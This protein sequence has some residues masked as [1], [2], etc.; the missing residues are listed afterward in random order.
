MANPEHV[1]IVRR[2]AEAIREWQDSNSGVQLDLRKADLSGV[3][4]IGAA[5][6]NADLGEATLCG[7]NLSG[8]ILY[9]ATLCEANLKLANLYE[10]KLGETNLQKA[11]LSDANLR[12]ASLKAANLAAANLTRANLAWADLRGANLPEANL[13]HA[14]LRGANLRGAVL[15]RAMLHFAELDGSILCDV[16][17]SG[18][19]LCNVDLRA[20]NLCSANL[21]GANLS[22]AVV[23]WT[24]FTDLDLSLV[25]QLET[26]RHGA[27][28]SVGIDTLYKSR[29][30]IPISFLS[31]CGVPDELVDYLRSSLSGQGAVQ[32]Y[33]C[34]ISYSHKDEEF[35]QRLHSRMRNEQLRVWFAPDDIKG[36]KKLHE[37]IEEAIRV[38]DKLLLVLSKHSMASE[39]VKTEIRRARQREVREGRRVLFPIRLLPFAKIRDWDAFDADTGNDIG[40]EVREYFIPDFSNWKDH[41]AFETAFKRLLDDLKAEAARDT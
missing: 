39:W 18:A 31:G 35:A 24:V 19:K 32:F 25:E 36:G 9:R 16:D 4:M 8:A 38:H 26:V 30:R 40:V 6:R 22:T 15:H 14:V 34:F 33:S 17:L 23:G 41:D 1:E 5:L 3:N 10:T 12:R 28:S 37:Q 2:G 20:A 27:P 13:S 11:N 21:R 7:T 29:G